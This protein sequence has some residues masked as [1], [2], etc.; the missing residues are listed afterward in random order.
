MRSLVKPVLTMFC[1][2]IL[3]V[4]SVSADCTRKGSC[5]AFGG[6]QHFYDYVSNG[7][8]SSADT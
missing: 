5:G 2:A 1:V 3:I 6:C 7:D 4:P 8:F